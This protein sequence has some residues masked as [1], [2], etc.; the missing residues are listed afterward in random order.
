MPKIDRVTITVKSD[1]LKKIDNLIDGK[2]IRNRSHAIES[3]LRESLHKTDINSALIM[4]GGNAPDLGPL[5]REIPKPLIPVHGKPI[6]YHQIK[7]LSRYGIDNLFVACGKEQDKI[8][9]YFGNGSRFGVNIEY[10]REERPLG[11]AGALGMLKGRLKNTFLMLNVDTLIDLDIFEAVRFHKSISTLATVVLANVDDPQHYG[12]ARMRGNRIL[13]F[14]EKPR[15]PPTN[16]INAGVAMFEP[17]VLNVV[18][19]GRLMIQELYKK[20]TAMKQLG[21][22]VYDGRIFDVGTATGYE[23]ALKGWKP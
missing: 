12:V 15:R 3:L 14:V 13:E 10:L 16:L 5:T 9:E 1:I 17:D 4:A 18:S 23:Q 2:T 11:T 7:F 22:Y 6:L 19:K 20:L 21:G 8:Q